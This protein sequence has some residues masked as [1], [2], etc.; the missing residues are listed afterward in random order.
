MFGG[1]Q[2]PTPGFTFGATPSA[3][4]TPATGGGF[5][6]GTPSTQATGNVSF[7]AAVG[8][9]PAAGPTSS[10]SF[11]ATPTA[12]TGG[13]KLGGTTPSFPSTQSSTAAPTAG[14]A[15]GTSTASTQSG[16]FKIGATT[17]PPAFPGTTSTAPGTTATVAP[18]MGFAMPIP[19][20]TATGGGG[21]GLGLGLGGAVKPTL[22]STTSTL[23]GLFN[24]QTPAAKP[25]GILGATT[26]TG[27][28]FGT[29]ATTSQTVGL[30]GVDPKT[31]TTAAGGSAADPKAGDGKTLKKSQVPPEIVKTVEDFKTYIKEEKTVQEGISRMSCKPMYKVQEDVASLKQLLSIVSNGLQRNACAV[32]KLKKEMTQE[33][34]N[35]EMAQRTKDIPAGLQY[36]NTAPTEYFQ[37]LVENFETQMLSYRQQIETLEGHLHSI[38]Q[39]SILSPEELVELLRKLHETFIALAAQLHQVHEAVKTQKEHYLNYRKIFLHDT[40]NIFER[41]KKA[42]KPKVLPEHFGPSPFSGLSNAA[43]VA[44][45]SALTKSQQPPAAAPPVAGLGTLGQT[46]GGFGSTGLFGATTTTAPAFGFGLG[47]SSTTVPPPAFGGFGST[48][49]TTTTT[50]SG[51]TGLNT[52][53]VRP[54]G[55]GTPAP[56]TTTTPSLFGTPQTVQTPAFGTPQGFPSAGGEQPFQLNKPPGSKRNKR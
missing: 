29:P 53:T 2:N 20:S 36:E 15:L 48:A 42:V 24:T 6:F 19:S 23:G 33:L 4:S 55:F 18:A 47:S 37:R 34:K 32:E 51:F 25:A 27:S 35:A 31:S 1:K 41:E 40:K 50:S 11:G 12:S 10:F 43:A 46:T 30:G 14:F 38:S 52:A 3:G 16:G 39:P 54:L 17:L 22:T 56:T 5:S 49:A 13:F 8:Q 9:T 28:V 7:G 26:A 44:M 45:A 21:M